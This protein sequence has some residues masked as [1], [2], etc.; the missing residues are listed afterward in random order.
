MHSGE[1]ESALVLYHRAA[2]VCPRDS[3]HGVAARRTA[4]TIN[5]WNRPEKSSMKLGEAASARRDATLKISVAE[6]SALKA[7]D[8]SKSCNSLSIIP[9]IFK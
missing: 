9:D 4:A 5:S 6:S 7:R 3:S 1:Y 2:T 8:V